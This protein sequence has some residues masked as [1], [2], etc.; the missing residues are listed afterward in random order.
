MVILSKFAES[1][2]AL[3]EEHNINAPA[4]AEKLNLHRTSITRYLCGERL[5]NY[6]DFVALI[7]YFNVSAD[8][9]LGRIDYCDVGEFH[10]IQ[11]FGTTL[12]QAMKDADVSQ[13]RIQKDLHFSSATTNSWVSNKKLPA[14]DRVDKLA[15]YLD[16]SVDYLL[17]RIR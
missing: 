14:M 8:V 6:E 1:L 3:M 9:L 10:P 12:Q 4:L 16:V 5:P 17:G 11:P 15:D 7:E 13:Y 2:S